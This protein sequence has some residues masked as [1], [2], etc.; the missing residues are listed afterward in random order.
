MQIKPLEINIDLK[1]TVNFNLNLQ[2]NYIYDLRANIFDDGIP[3]DITGCS[4]QL[5]LIK[6]DETYIIQTADITVNEGYINIRLDKDFT[7]V[8]GQA[9]LQ[10]LIS[11]NNVINGSWVIECEIK[12]AALQ[13]EYISSNKTTIVEDLNVKI[14]EA[15]A[16]INEINTLLTTNN[17]ALKSD[18][19]PINTSLTQINSNVTGLSNNKV[20]K[21]TGKGLSTNDFTTAL[22]TEVEK[23]KNIESSLSNKMEATKGGSNDKFT[24]L[25]LGDYT[26][27]G[28]SGY[29]QLPNGLILQW[30]KVSGA[31]N[32]NSSTGR[33][34]ITLP[35]PL[36][37]RGLVSI[38]TPSNNNTIGN[39][40]WLANVNASCRFVDNTK[41]EYEIGNSGTNFPSQYDIECSW[42]AIGY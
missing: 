16:K 32:P 1:R 30:G 13:D 14:A 24:S 20:D 11:Q 31:V 29:T 41:L 34:P 28:T 10:I 35:K 4:V 39:I 2:Q 18:L 9:K 6:P 26:T 33:L 38:I 5:H 17:I 27:A 42:I 8:Y 3:A 21:V 23:I 19:T 37:N 25:F 36:P 12:K 22:K 15:A 7:R 40:S